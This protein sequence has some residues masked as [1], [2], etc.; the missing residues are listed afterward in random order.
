MQQQRSQ[1]Y[2][3]RCPCMGTGGKDVEQ[4]IGDCD[5]SESQAPTDSDFR[6]SHSRIPCSTSFPP[7]PMQQ[8]RSQCYSARCPCMG[9]GGKDVEQGIGDCD[10]SESQGPTGSDFR[11][12]HSR[13]PCSTSFP[14]VPMQGQRAECYS[15]RCPCMGTGGKDV[16][17]GIGDFD[18]SESQAP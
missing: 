15:A 12:W 11:K 2:S 9:T 3:A 1:C 4:G 16:E 6:K 7:V 10:V 17:Q 14:P 13:I 5:V 8:Q 18:A